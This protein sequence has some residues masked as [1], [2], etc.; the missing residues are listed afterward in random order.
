MTDH[1]TV[2]PQALSKAV[3]EA[4]GS[5][6][7]LPQ[8]MAD[9]QGVYGLEGVF[10]TIYLKG[11]IV[12]KVSVFIRDSSAARVVARMLGVDDLEEES[13][14]TLDGIGEVLNIITGCFKKNIDS[15]QVHADISVPS[16]RLTSV[17]PPGRWENNVEQS[18][19]AGDVT[20]KIMLSYRL[21]STEEKKGVPP[22]TG[23]AKMKLS[24]A[25]LLKQALARKK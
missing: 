19:S 17:L 3:I 7:D 5:V 16:T 21:V 13:S 14:K 10:S 6:Y 15:H 4:V 12:G 25:E 22:P 9:D 8:L 1:Q 23:M 11:D 20:F 2:F 24:A 18:F